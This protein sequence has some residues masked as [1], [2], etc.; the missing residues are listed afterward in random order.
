M[1]VAYTEDA[2]RARTKTVTRRTGWWKDRNGRHIIKPGDRLTLCR[3]LMGIRRGEKIER[4]CEVEVVSVRRERLDELVRFSTGWVE[5]RDLTSS[6]LAAQASLYAYG[7]SEMVREGFPDLHP[8][9][10]IKRYFIEAQGI[11]HT[12]E[13]TRIEWKYLDG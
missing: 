3:K 6:V 9:E 10:F 12:A 13:V 4:I 7:V 2:V 8:A 1:S 5:P 11:P